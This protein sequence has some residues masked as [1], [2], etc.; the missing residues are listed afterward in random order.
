MKDDAGDTDLFFPGRHSKREY[1]RHAPR[2]YRLRRRLSAIFVGFMGASFAV[3]V[4]PKPNNYGYSCL[5][6]MVLGAFVLFKRFT[7]KRDMDVMV[8]GALAGE[9]ETPPGGPAAM[10]VDLHDSDFRA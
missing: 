6:M 1:E 5:A 10:N 3:S 8:E 4:V 2:Q 9:R 7:L